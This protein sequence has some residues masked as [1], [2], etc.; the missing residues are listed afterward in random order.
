MKKTVLR[1]VSL[2][3]ML[4]PMEWVHLLVRGARS[5]RWWVGI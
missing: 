1:I 4:I 2:A 5:L 3:A